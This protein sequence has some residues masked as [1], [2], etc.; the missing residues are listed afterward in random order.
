M[1]ID[2]HVHTTKGGYDSALSMPQLVTALE[3]SGLD[4]VCVTEHNCAWT[5]EEL[6]KIASNH[7]VTVLA[8]MEVETDVGHIVI[9]G[10]DRYISGVHK[11]SKLRQITDEMGGFLIGVHPF[12]RFFDLD[13]LG[14]KLK[15]DRSQALKE[16]IAHPILDV[17]DEIEVLNGCCA[18]RENSL[19]L[20]VA[21]KLGLRGTAGSDAH[22]THGLGS[23][24]TVFQREIRNESE[25]IAEL[26]AGRYYPAQ[27]LP[28]GEI[29]PYSYQYPLARGNLYEPDV[30]FP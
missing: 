11:A 7:N 24:V 29:V 4:G 18:D 17:V 10:L 14:V 13:D 20:E 25:L 3:R 16:A 1:I 27:R 5:R 9:L 22:S 8:G 2:L 12:R 23:S 26:R 28:S 19:A 15:H 6:E 30:R 21:R